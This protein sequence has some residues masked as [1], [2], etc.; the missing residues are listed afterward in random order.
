MHVTYK[1]KKWRKINALLSM[2]TWLDAPRVMWSCF[3]QPYGFSLYHV[4]VVK[5]ALS[6]ELIEKTHSAIRSQEDQCFAFISHD[7]FAPLRQLTLGRRPRSWYVSSSIEHIDSTWEAQMF[8]FQDHRTLN[9]FF[10]RSFNPSLNRVLFCS[11]VKAAQQR[12]KKSNESRHHTDTVI[13][14]L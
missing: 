10:M 14:G 2:L 9:F 5:A 1:T 13:H 12:K 7:M 8:S 4:E 3:L 6:A 11:Q